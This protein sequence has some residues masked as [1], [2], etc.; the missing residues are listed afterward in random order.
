M[1]C[2]ASSLMDFTVDI[3]VAALGDL[4]IP[5]P[6]RRLAATMLR[7]GASIWTGAGSEADPPAVGRIR[8]RDAER[9]AG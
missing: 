8:R 4:L 9:V 5:D 6:G 7:A 1:T 2:S 3:A